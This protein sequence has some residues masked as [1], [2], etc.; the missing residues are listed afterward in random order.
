[1]TLVDRVKVYLP[2]AFPDIWHIDKEDD[3][4]SLVGKGSHHSPGLG[5]SS[6]D[7]TSPEIDMENR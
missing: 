6:L 5:L 2:F 3:T 4:V 7:K 1:M